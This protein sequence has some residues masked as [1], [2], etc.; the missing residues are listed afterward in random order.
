MQRML[1]LQGVGRAPTSLTDTI[2]TLLHFQIKT[3]TIHIFYPTYL[4]C[5]C[6]NIQA[7]FFVFHQHGPPHL[8]TL[9]VY[10]IGI[11]LV[12]PVDQ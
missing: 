3:N 1:L 8:S 10:Y 4:D 9:V 2:F 7:L 12:R 11:F 6:N 5:K